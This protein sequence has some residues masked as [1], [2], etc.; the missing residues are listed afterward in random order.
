M[1][2]VITV[3]LQLFWVVYAVLVVLRIGVGLLN[4]E[5]STAPLIS[6]LVETGSM[7]PTIF[8]GDVIFIRPVERYRMNDIITF[9]NEEGKT[10]THR[11]VEEDKRTAETR[12]VTQGDNNNTEDLSEVSY[13]QVIGKYWFRL[14]WFGSVLRHLGS[15]VGTVLFIAVPVMV[16]LLEKILQKREAGRFSDL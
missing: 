9:R 4:K 7:E 6:Y 5:H 8:A 2:R 14:P 12:F 15:P 10:I 3:S 1:R 16:L 13:R 11:I